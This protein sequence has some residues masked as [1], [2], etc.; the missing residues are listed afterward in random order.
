MSSD[1]YARR[2]FKTRLCRFFS[3]SK[4][5]K[6]AECSHAHSREELLERPNLRKTA[7]CRNW[8]I[9][10]SCDKGKK[11]PY[12]HGLC[13]LR[14][15][16]SLD[17]PP[18]MPYSG[19]SNKS[20]SNCEAELNGGEREHQRRPHHPRKYASHRISG[21]SFGCPERGLSR[22]STSTSG[23]AWCSPVWVNYDL[24]CYVLPAL[25]AYQYQYAPFPYQSYENNPHGASQDYL[26]PAS[27]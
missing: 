4:C 12:A 9:S 16:E 19:S 27:T 20:H 13:E 2:F 23:N 6:G 25:T 11:C 22:S 15:L 1:D 8:S 5:F 24:P 26:F 3:N 17:S 18:Q 14:A 10:S 7:L 21:E